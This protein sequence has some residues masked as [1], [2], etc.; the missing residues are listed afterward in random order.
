[1]TI[2]G[3]KSAIVE[4]G[5]EVNPLMPAANMLKTTKRYERSAF[6]RKLAT[7]SNPLEASASVA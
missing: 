2:S 3:E 1:M 6:I 7:S 4:M 5:Q